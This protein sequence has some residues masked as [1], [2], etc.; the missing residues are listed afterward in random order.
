[1]LGGLISPL[2]SNVFY[3][4]FIHAM[5]LI[6]LSQSI[7]D[8]SPARLAFLLLWLISKLVIIHGATMHPQAQTTPALTSPDRCTLES[9]CPI[10]ILNLLNQP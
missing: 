3:E 10:L 5:S 7:C 6:F 8:D 2:L 4:E 1:M 9:L